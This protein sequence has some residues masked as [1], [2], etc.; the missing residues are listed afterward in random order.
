MASVASSRFLTHA[1]RAYVLF[2]ARLQVQ[3][4][5]TVRMGVRL[6]NALDHGYDRS[7]DPHPS[8]GLLMR[9]RTFMLDVKLDF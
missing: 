2:N 3:V 4:A 9:C 8:P 6:D 7:D 1:E 5:P